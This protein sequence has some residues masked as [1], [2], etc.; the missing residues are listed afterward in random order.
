MTDNPALTRYIRQV[1]AALD[2]IDPDERDAIVSE[3]K[4]HITEATTAGRDLDAVLAGLGPAQKLAKAYEVELLLNRKR[5]G[6]NVDGFF[7]VV[8]AL[9]TLS[10]PTVIIGSVLGVV[11]ATFLVVGV[12][13]FLLGLLQP[14]LPAAWIPPDFQRSEALIWGIPLAIAGTF[15]LS[16]FFAYARFI[17]H[18]VRGIA[19]GG[20]IELHRGLLPKW[21]QRL[22]LRMKKG[23]TTRQSV[24]LAILLTGSS[25][26]AQAQSGFRLVEVH[27]GGAGRKY[28]AGVWYP[29]VASS[30][31]PMT[32]RDY[33]ATMS[34]HRAQ[35]DSPDS[36][37][38][39]IR[40]YA[41]LMENGGVKNAFDRL[42][43]VS[44]TALR[45]APLRTRARLPVV[46]IA[47]GNFHTLMHQAPLAEALADRGYAVISVPFPFHID[48]PPAASATVLS[49]AD[50]HAADLRRAIHA[51]RSVVLIDSADVTVI[52]HSFGARSALLIALETPVKALVSLDGGI[53]NRAGNDW[54]DGSKYDAA[55]LHAPVLHVF[56]TADSIVVPD[57]TLL[58]RMV[59]SDQLRI[60]VA[61]MR[62]AEFTVFGS[63]IAAFPELI[64]G[65]VPADV[66]QRVAYVQNLVL[67]YVD[68]MRKT[69]DI[70]A[71]NA[72]SQLASVEPR[73]AD[74][75][76]CASR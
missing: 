25:L 39:A 50:T 32:L 19:R 26:N 31:A 5:W 16:L 52:G 43:T 3:L 34:R 21:V 49:I 54:L 10:L 15:A 59:G 20:P 17:L 48:G 8:G 67:Q 65:S 30:M 63:L 51:A 9:A 6:G 37:I 27:G 41:A 18:V 38:A 44:L 29:A 45:D 40:E 62:H 28:I 64:E 13:V 22:V 71:V 56:Q 4:S 11:G 53:A 74:S 35:P 23:D 58:N 68:T 60:N 24:V 70:C 47:Q 12:G 66:Q 61:G 57:M 46:L 55:Q 72:S 69:R 14:L 33:V 76:R 73:L 36:A 2:S 75:R 42:G 1:E 7:R